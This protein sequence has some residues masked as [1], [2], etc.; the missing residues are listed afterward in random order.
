MRT[1][2]VPSKE[3]PRRL[4]VELALEPREVVGERVDELG[5]DRVLDDRVAVARDPVEMGLA[6]V[7]VLLYREAPAQVY[8]AFRPTITSSRVDARGARKR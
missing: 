3:L 6:R 8:E 7:H 4:D 1:V 2:C 5:L